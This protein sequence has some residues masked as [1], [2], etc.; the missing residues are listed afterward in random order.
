M[1]SDIIII[2]VGVMFNSFAKKKCL[3]VPGGKNVLFNVENLNV[4]LFRSVAMDKVFF[5]YAGQ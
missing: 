1:H 3:Q 2:Q 4:W 5:P